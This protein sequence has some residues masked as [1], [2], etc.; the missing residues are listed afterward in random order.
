MGQDLAYFNGRF[1]A[2]DDPVLPIEER[3]LQFGDGIYE[4]LRIYDGHPYTVAEHIDRL[5]NSAAAILLDLPLSKQELSD[6]VYGGIA[7]AGIR[8]GTVY[9]QVTRGSSPRN[10]VFPIGVQANLYVIWKEGV[11][12]LT[13]LRQQGITAH[14]F[15]DE[16][17]SNCYIKSLCLLPNVLA[18]E[19]ARRLGAHEALFV[20]DGKLKEGASANVFIVKDGTFFTPAADRSILNGITRQKMIALLRAHN[21]TV[22]EGDIP[23]AMLQEA[24]EVFITS[25]IQE[26]LPIIRVDETVIGSGM[27]GPYFAKLLTW[28]EEDVQRTIAAMED[29]QV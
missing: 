22:T 7:R 23:A 21:V 20:R 17:W 12:E 2:L 8:Q 19:K 26:A 29:A 5:W 11:A 16:R 10:H 27:P 9:I 13:Q 28:Y 25:S 18:K 1:I 3:G 6:L 14:T 15:E 24:E 4:M